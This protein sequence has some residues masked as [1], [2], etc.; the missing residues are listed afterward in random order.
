MLGSTLCAADPLRSSGDNSHG[1]TGGVHR[2]N[3]EE[4]K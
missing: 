3:I 4:N 1:E 2:P